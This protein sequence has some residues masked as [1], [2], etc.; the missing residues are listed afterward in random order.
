M[1]DPSTA[2]IKALL[3]EHM[4]ASREER[5]ADAEFR[6]DLRVRVERLTNQVGDVSAG[7]RDLQRRVGKLE[8][9]QAETRAIANEAR[10]SSAEVEGKLIGQVAAIRTDMADLKGDVATV[11]AIAPLVQ[12]IRTEQVTRAAE[13]AAEATLRA[14]V[15]AKAKAEKDAAEAK[16]KAERD[17]ADAEERTARLALQQRRTFYIKLLAVITPVLISI[18]GVITAMVAARPTSSPAPSTPAVII[19]AGH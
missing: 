10:S 2:E 3:Q 14:E 16:A 4:R 8:E 12:E 17:E 15:E 1:T 18:A 7:L 13:R 6:G 19:D 5:T 9:Q 11:I